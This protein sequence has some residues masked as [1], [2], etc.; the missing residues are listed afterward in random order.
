MRSR[1]I[2]VFASAATSLVVISWAEIGSEPSHR[3]QMRSGA[4]LCYRQAGRLHR[5]G[6][7]AERRPGG[8]G[9]LLASGSTPTPAICNCKEVAIPLCPQ[10]PWE[11]GGLGE[12][13]SR[14]PSLA[15]E[16]QPVGLSRAITCICGQNGASSPVRTVGRGRTRAE[17]KLSC[18]LAAE[19]MGR[20]GMGVCP[21]HDCP[22]ALVT[23]HT[24][25]CL[26]SPL[27]SPSNGGS[28]RVGFAL[29][30]LWGLQLL[31]WGLPCL[32]AS[33]VP[34]I[35]NRGSDGWHLS[36]AGS[37]SLH[38]GLQLPWVPSPGSCRPP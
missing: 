32:E 13:A 15:E 12:T 16:A 3:T 18:P 20:G 1:S 29:L 6:L 28:L 7:W 10:R 35:R 5:A 4:P 21:S 24:L 27:P 22:W 38:R 2:C 19:E 36:R 31:A 8:F 26:D 11:A 17:S 23:D 9:G 33:L 25:V 34:G 14:G 37:G 30:L